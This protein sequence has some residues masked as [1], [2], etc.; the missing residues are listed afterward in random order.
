MKPLPESFT[1]AVVDNWC[2]S[3]TH[4]ETASTENTDGVQPYPQ[5]AITD[6]TDEEVVASLPEG[7]GSRA[8]CPVG[9]EVF[10]LVRAEVVPEHEHLVGLDGGEHAV[11]RHRRKLCRSVFYRNSTLALRWES[12]LVG[13]AC[14]VVGACANSQQAQTS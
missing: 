12:P 2:S 4:R 5:S 6:D 1:L 10:P 14:S 13:V 7:D 9:E 8:I 11:P 3:C